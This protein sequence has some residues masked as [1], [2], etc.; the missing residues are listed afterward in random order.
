MQA[1]IEPEPTESLLT[2]WGRTAPTRSFVHSPGTGEELATLFENPPERGLIGRGLG[3]SYGDAAQN[4][5]GAVLSSLKMTGIGPIDEE[6]GEITVD[7]GVSFDDL[8]KAIVPRGWFPPVTPG[9]RFITVGG[10]IAADIHGKNHHI[11][12]SFCSHVEGMT[13]QTGRGIVRASKA[14]N[15]DLFWGTAGGMGLTGFVVAATVKLL[16]I[17][18]PAVKIDTER[19]RDLDDL[20]N[21]MESGDDN[22]RYSVAWID[23]LTGGSSLGRGVLT[24]GDH[25]HPDELKGRRRKRFMTYAPRD[26]VGLPVPIPGFALN[27][28]T[29]RAFNEVWYRKAPTQANRAL[30]PLAPF[31]YPLDS[32][33]QWNRFY[34]P[35]GFVQYQFVVPMSEHEVVRRVIE[36]LSQSKSA[37]FLAVLK[38]L[39]ASNE[40]DLSFPIPGWTLAVDLPVRNAELAGMLHEFDRIVAESGGRI[41]LAKDARLRADVLEIMYPNLSR[42]REVKARWDPN[43]VMRSDLARRLGLA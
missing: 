37:P 20:M 1:D 2:G 28:G 32:I 19:A 43:G 25:A 18:T 4:A 8:L 23:C 10:A 36:S 42:W 26:P 6:R 30:A 9:T 7:G 12:G 38:R 34:G 33:D 24:R 13:I 14:E 41:Y 39:G 40:S 5:G 3:R 27:R 21:R 35:R 17:D 11:E 22:Y 31:F 15:A 16:R 29:V